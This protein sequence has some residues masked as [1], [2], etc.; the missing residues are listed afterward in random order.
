M[1]KLMLSWYNS[2]NPSATGE[3]P[4][5]D[6]REIFQLQDKAVPG[7]LQKFESEFRWC[8]RALELTLDS[9][10]FFGRNTE[11]L[12]HREHLRDS[13]PNAFY[14]MNVVVNLAYDALGSLISALRLL[15]YGVLADTWALMRC[16]FESA[17]YAD[18]FTRNDTKVAGFL[19]VGQRIKADSSM[20]VAVELRRKGLGF[21][22]VRKFL[23][24]K[25]SQNMGQFYS[26]LCSFGAHAS[27]VR[28]GFRISQNEPEVRAYLSIGHRNMAFCLAGYA[29][30]VSYTMGILFDAWPQLLQNQPALL[31]R[32]KALNDEY[33]CVFGVKSDAG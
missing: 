3:S 14:Q 5:M 18:Y 9:F 17:C 32:Y 13:D 16:A 19:D 22:E 8:R 11:I 6:I 25:Y 15:E 33:Q 7:N 23:E 10:E 20:N 2:M 4:L 29:A 26:T 21:D 1:S 28:S 27:P 31:I 24:K 12:A 30:T